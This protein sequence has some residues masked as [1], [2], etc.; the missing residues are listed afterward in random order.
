VENAKPAGREIRLKPE[1]CNTRVEA[2][3]M[4]HDNYTEEYIRSILIES[5]TIALVGASPKADR[6]S[7]GV[8][9]FLLSQGYDVYPVNPGQAGKEILGRK[10]YAT[11][12]DIPVAIDM[13][14]VFRAPEY[15]MDVVNEALALEDKP[16]VIWGQLGVRNDQAAAKAEEAGVKVVMDRCPAIEI[17][18]LNIRR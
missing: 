9:Q 13:V 7:Y 18:R 1:C 11:L 2:T 8:M 5:H 3:A 16:K 4:N 14:D 15:L 6:P 17:P 10:V 12:S